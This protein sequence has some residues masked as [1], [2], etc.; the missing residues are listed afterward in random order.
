[1]VVATLP[2]FTGAEG[3]KIV[4]S[5]MVTG[6]KALYG[7]SQDINDYLDEHIEQMKLSENLTVSRTGRILEMAK[8]GFGMGYITSV[9]VIATGQLILGNALSAVTTIATAATLT[10]PIAMTCAAVGAIYY[11]WNALS[12]QEKNE[13]LEKLSHGLEIGIEMIKSVIRFLVEKTKEILTSDNLTE[14]KKNISLAAAVFGK[15]LGDIT[16][17]LIDK[18]ADGLDVIK[19]T[20]SKAMAD[21][22]DLASDAYEVI[23]DKSG[24]A[25]DLASETFDSVK[26]HGEKAID[27]IKSK[28]RDAGEKVN[29]DSLGCDDINLSK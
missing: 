17:K 23:K 14:I 12:E 24:K 21:T 27:R 19:S 22:A 10:N 13:L 6:I 7:I 26:E 11:G 16:H 9:V 25:A 2:I 15:T 5:A 4:S 18:A 3:L 28:K 8:Y 20:T 1:M 29:Q